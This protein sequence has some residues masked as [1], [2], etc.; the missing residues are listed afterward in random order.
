VNQYDPIV[1][2]SGVLTT[3]GVDTLRDDLTAKALLTTAALATGDVCQMSGDT[4]LAKAVNTNADPCVGVYNGVTSSIVQEGAVAVTLAAGVVLANGDAV[5]LAAQPGRVTNVKPTTDMLHELGVVLDA[6]SATIFWQPRP[7]V[8]RAAS[9]LMFDARSSWLLQGDA[10]PAQPGEQQA[11]P[12]TAVDLIAALGATGVILPAS[13]LAIYQ[14][15]TASP[16][17]DSLGLGPNLVAAGGPL[18]GR[19][20][21]GLG[22]AGS[23][24]SKVGVETTAIT[25]VFQAAVA[26]FADANNSIVSVLIVARPNSNVNLFGLAAHRAGVPGWESGVTAL[27][28][29]GIVNASLLGVNYIPCGAYI[30][31]AHVINDVAFSHQLFTSE[32][33]S[34]PGAY[35]ASASSPSPLTIGGTWNFGGTA[36]QVAYLAVLNVA[37][38]SAQRAAFWRQCRQAAFNV[39]VTYTRA[40]P[41]VVP[42]TASRVACYG[43]NQPAIGWNTNFVAGTDNLLQSGVVA[44]D[45]ASFV[46]INSNDIANNV[47]WIDVGTAG[48]AADGPSGMRDAVR[49]TMANGWNPMANGYRC[50]IGAMA[51]VGASNVSFVLSVWR[52]QATV[53]TTFRAGVWYTGDAGGSEYIAFINDA[54]TPATWGGTFAAAGPVRAAQTGVQVLIGATNNADD[55]DVAELALVQNRATALLAWRRTDA[56][57]AA[58]AIPTCS[59]TNVGNARYSPAKGRINVRV[60]G[61][62]DTPNS[63]ILCCGVVAGQGCL[64]LSLTTGGA[65]LSLGIWDDSA[66]QVIN[67]TSLTFTAG[68]EYNLTVEWN[69]AA[70]TAS[71]M[72]GATVIGSAVV[73]PWTPE[74][75]DVTPIYIGSQSGPAAAANG[76]IALLQLVNT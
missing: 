68:A 10:P 7:V 41:L 17:V 73:A 35:G 38:T 24:T 61:C 19:E 70:G 48:A 31:V 37:I 33:D 67:I 2:K 12:S 22:Q 36:G 72:Q 16:L 14:A 60:A 69:A 5:Y 46:G 56:A 40:G 3:L 58:T 63:R 57:A 39:P 75:L 71:I 28:I 45:G 26:A 74:P 21:V 66:V 15:D 23:F 44:E 20:C 27:Q 51:I 11:F 29:Q 4:T 13:V 54:A 50:N 49:V 47:N 62:Q 8:V 65:G 30:C 59:I 1:I 32:G 42:I 6:A 64:L 52:K 53:G 34:A 9:T 25:Q 43:A 18:T 55:V 76:L